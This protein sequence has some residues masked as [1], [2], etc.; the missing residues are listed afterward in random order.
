MYDS[1]VAILLG[2][3]GNIK[4]NTSGNTTFTKFSIA[5]T[6]KKGDEYITDWHNCVAFGKTADMIW[7]KVKKGHKIQ[8]NGRIQYSKYE[9]NGEE[10]TGIEIIVDRITFIG[11]VQKEEEN[12]NQPSQESHAG[13]HQT[14]LLSDDVPF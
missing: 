1:A 6:H 14:E 3:V 7:D 4:N 8:V 13:D 12:A 9:K 5:T 11:K 10:R 2:N